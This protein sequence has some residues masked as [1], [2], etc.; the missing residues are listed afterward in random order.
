MTIQDQIE[1]YRKPLTGYAFVLCRANQHNA[2]DLFQETCLK[3]LQAEKKNQFLQGTNFKAF[4]HTVMRNTFITTYRK[5]LQMQAPDDV[6]DYSLLIEFRMI[7]NTTGESL[8]VEKDLVSTINT[9]E[10]KKLKVLSLYISG[11]KYVEIAEKLN[12]PLGTIKSRMFLA[13]KQ[14]S[15]KLNDA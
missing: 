12:L 6:I 2:E 13:R 15:K 8:L 10:K 11:Y 5:K 9:I 1:K 14:L 7:D 4:A 3:V